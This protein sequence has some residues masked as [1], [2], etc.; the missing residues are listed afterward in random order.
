MYIEDRTGLT[1]DQSSRFHRSERVIRPFGVVLAR[2]DSI[3]AGCVDRLDLAGV[4]QLRRQPK[5]V[6]SEQH[7]E[8]L[9]P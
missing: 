5:E 2:R 8:V 4:V 7:F 6:A 1:I 9:H 3:H